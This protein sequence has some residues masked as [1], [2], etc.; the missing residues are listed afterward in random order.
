M[1]PAAVVAGLGIAQGDRRAPSTLAAGDE[2]PMNSRE[3]RVQRAFSR[4]LVTLVCSARCYP[5]N[6]APNP[7]SEPAREGPNDRKMGEHF[8][9]NRPPTHLGE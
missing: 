4:G 7:I 3:R 5:M 8:S 9:A 6:G 2:S 1:N